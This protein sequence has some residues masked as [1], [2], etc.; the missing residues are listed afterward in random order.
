[1]SRWFLFLGA[2]LLLHLT[3]TTKGFH[4]VIFIVHLNSSPNYI[5]LLYFN[6]IYLPFPD[7]LAALPIPTS[8]SKMTIA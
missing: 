6:Q 8:A 2:Q 4:I 3:P 1:M 5:P 7:V